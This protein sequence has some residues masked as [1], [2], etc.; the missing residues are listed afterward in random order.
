MLSLRNQILL[1]LMITVLLIAGAIAGA[2]WINTSQHTESQ[3][4]RSL[5]VAAD[6]FEQ[7]LRSREESLINSAELL[8]SDFGFKQAVAT[9]DGATIDSA[10]FNHG[11]R[12]KADLMFL[13]DLGGSLVASTHASL[14]VQK[15]FPHP[16]LIQNAA[17]SGGALA[18][19]RIEDDLYQVVVVA[20][21]APVPIGFTGVGFR[22]NESVARELKQLANIEVTFLINGLSNVRT[23][24]T[25]EPQQAEI[26]MQSPDRLASN[27]ALLFPATQDYVSKIVNLEG[28]E[29]GLGQAY[30]SVPIAP[31]LEEYRLL[32][33]EIL[34]IA[35][36]MLLISALAGTVFTRTITNPLKAVVGLAQKLSN[37]NYETRLAD[38][39]GAREVRNLYQAVSQ[40]GE[41]VR[42][43][44]Q[45]LEFQAEHDKLTGVLNRST[46][47]D[48]LDNELRDEPAQRILACV[49]I[50]SF[51][52]INDSL[53]P[54]VG[55]EV[56][57][58]VASRL[59]DE[60]DSRA[61]T[62]RY[63]G[64][65]FVVVL[66]VG[67]EE[68]EARLLN[69]VESISSNYRVG[70]LELSL[71]FRVGFSVFPDDASTAELLMRRA[72]IAIDRARSENTDFRRYQEGED[73]EYGH[74]LHLIR[75]L[76]SA[77]E[78]D[79][80]QLFMNYQPKLNLS[81]GRVDKLEALIRWIHPDEGFISPEY[82]VALAEQ[83]G[84]IKD[85][86]D[87]VVRKVIA[88]RS[89]WQ[90]D[91]PNLQVAINVSAQDLERDDLL[92][93]TLAQ[94]RDAGLSEKSICFEMT[95]RDM[96]S[97]ADKAF[98]L[99]S[100]YRDAGF[101]LSVD[102][103][104]IGQS[105]LSKLKHMPV[106]EIKI[107]K[108]FITNLE[109]SFDDQTIVR[110]TIKLGHDFD[111]RVIAEGVESLAATE[112]LAEMGCDYIQ[113]Y[114]LSKPMVGSDFSGW[115][116]QFERSKYEEFKGVLVA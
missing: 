44:E 79:D 70:D 15:P 51:R 9:R 23:I 12:V 6:T 61:L 90:A 108:V 115:V 101:D 107:D 98:D 49:N 84:L 25:L 104:G 13:T 69:L 85:M 57:R 17:K 105:S 103:Y 20:V 66:Q 106:N 31:Y 94:L 65:E 87:W 76:G 46:L 18:F 64:D 29:D 63:G 95:E 40:L 7:L 11:D 86:T 102:D 109:S 72:T 1:L 97:D 28:A 33:N 111:L 14:R 54:V 16:E 68:G 74:R 88:E 43:R 2:S 75:L 60:T 62:G 112:L 73:E 100:L 34:V 47:V 58:Q 52:G 82:F 48:R 26:A 116:E 83:S 114:F 77:L 41:D 21:N 67:S 8:T 71:S 89:L 50:K 91:F 110:S 22:L 80:G 24:S 78:A 32:R 37:G 81:T 59:C 92:P 113:G 56:L 39:G 42:V 53:G 99:M 30:L 10:L 93:A 3:V 5:S 27:I 55:D 4:D 36:L 96:M 35:A 38:Q 19:V 45:K